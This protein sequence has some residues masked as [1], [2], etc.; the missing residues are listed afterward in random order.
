MTI[1]KRVVHGRLNITRKGTIM[2]NLG[3]GRGIA[4]SDLLFPS[5]PDLNALEVKYISSDE[6]PE[7]GKFFNSF[8]FYGDLPFDIEGWRFVLREVYPGKE[9]KEVPIS[10]ALYAYLEEDGIK[11]KEKRFEFVG[12]RYF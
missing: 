12:K 5:R 10:Q 6:I 2:F 7:K 1:E 3:K 8:I 4:P 9:K 11:I